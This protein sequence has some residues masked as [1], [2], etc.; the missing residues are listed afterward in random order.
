MSGHQE[1]VGS[2]FVCAPPAPQGPTKQVEGEEIRKDEGN[3][4]LMGCWIDKTNK[5]VSRRGVSSCFLLVKL[6]LWCVFCCNFLFNEVSLVSSFAR[7]V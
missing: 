5:Q 6:R 2:G 1:E 3:K 4:V 7:L